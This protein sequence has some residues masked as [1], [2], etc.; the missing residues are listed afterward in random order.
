MF[1]LVSIILNNIL[2]QKTTSAKLLNYFIESANIESKDKNNL[3]AYKQL[4]EYYINLD[5]SKSLQY[6]EKCNN[7]YSAYPLYSILLNNL[8]EYEQSQDIFERGVAKGYF[9]KESYIIYLNTLN[10]LNVELDKNISRLCKLLQMCFI[11]FMK[12]ELYFLFEFLTLYKLI[13][14]KYF[15][16]NGEM[17]FKCNIY[18]EF[19]QI[20]ENFLF[21]EENKGKVEKIK[22]VKNLQQSDYLEF[23]RVYGYLFYMGGN[24]EKLV[25][26]NK[27]NCNKCEH[28][29][30]MILEEKNLDQNLKSFCY[31]YLSKCLKKKIN[32]MS[33]FS[34]LGVFFRSMDTDLHKFEKNKKDMFNS[35]NDIINKTSTYKYAS[36]FFFKLGKM[37]NEGLGVKRNVFKAF[38]FF[39]LGAQSDSL[40]LTIEENIES[41]YRNKSCKKILDDKDFKAEANRWLDEKIEDKYTDDGCGICYANSP[42]NIFFPCLHYI[43]CNDCVEMLYKR[44]KNPSCPFCRHPINHTVKV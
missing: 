10:K 41:L 11:G 28:I 37:Y 17:L 42:Q 7:Y 16:V 35:I 12:G 3:E 24:K 21:T 31:I 5:N 14:Y 36:S 20:C 6:F 9:D 15:K 34:E 32:L 22:N 2:E 40:G 4:G 38:S 33:G 29:F 8:K 44:S 23:L 39:K 26:I 19:F 1:K 43:C 30:H 18:Y 27:D 25:E 13:T